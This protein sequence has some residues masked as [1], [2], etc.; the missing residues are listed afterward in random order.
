[1]LEEGAPLYDEWANEVLTAARH[2]DIWGNYIPLAEAINPR[3]AD[4]VVVDPRDAARPLF[5]KDVGLFHDAD[6]QTDASKRLLVPRK[7]EILHYTSARTFI[8]DGVSEE[9]GVAIHA[10]DSLRFAVAISV[11]LVDDVF[12]VHTQTATAQINQLVQ[13]RMMEEPADPSAAL[14]AIREDL[15]PLWDSSLEQPGMEHD[16]ESLERFFA[17][18]RLA[19]IARSLGNHTLLANLE[20]F[21]VT[22]FDKLGDP[23]AVIGVKWVKPDGDEKGIPR[24]IH[25]WQYRGHHF[26]LTSTSNPSQPRSVLTYDATSDTFDAQPNVIQNLHAALKQQNQDGL[27]ESSH[28][29]AGNIAR[30]ERPLSVGCPVHNLGTIAASAHFGAD[31][32]EHMVN[33]YRERPLRVS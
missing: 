30:L 28:K 25:G 14:E 21:S 29:S 16:A 24:A 8:K 12:T 2:P 9:E 15:G 17:L 4:G 1:M 26:G 3:M 11:G 22:A 7:D 5:R 33:Y 31:V 19:F 32:F 27:R 23:S 18:Q 10:R 6:A 13:K 20:A